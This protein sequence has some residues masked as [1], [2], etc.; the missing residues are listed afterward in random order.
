MDRTFT[1]AAGQRVRFRGLVVARGTFEAA[2]LLEPL[3]DGQQVGATSFYGSDPKV[4]SRFAYDG[5]ASTAWVSSDTGPRPTLLFRWRDQQVIR[6]LGVEGGSDEAPVGAIVRSGGRTE[7][8]GSGVVHRRAAAAVPHASARGH[9][10]E[11]RRTPSMSSS[12]SS[13]S[14]VPIIV[15]AVRG[16]HPDGC[17][18]AVSDRCSR[19][20]ARWCRHPGPRHDGG[21]RQRDP[22]A[23]VE[24]AVRRRRDRSMTA[25]ARLAPH[26]NAEFEV[27]QIAGVPMGSPASADRATHAW[28]RSSAGGTHRER[29]RSPSGG[30]ES[31]VPSR[32]LQSGLGW[33]RWTARS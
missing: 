13:I 7:R 16:R 11:G 25:A 24:A 29:G 32:E 23:T 6:G 2:R 4:S 33:P 20:T 9:L 5:E 10:P 17:R 18:S 3:G 19:S 8:V 21:H 26:A 27:I 22:L 28:P 31:L 12:P 1:L 30:E 14:R 15:R